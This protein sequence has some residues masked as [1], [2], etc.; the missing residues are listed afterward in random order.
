MD[1]KIGMTVAVMFLLI[2]VTMTIK[3]QI[4]SI[5]TSAEF[6]KDAVA[7]TTRSAATTLHIMG[8]SDDYEF[9]EF[10][11]DEFDDLMYNCGRSTNLAALEGDVKVARERN[12]GSCT[13]SREPYDYW[14]NNGILS[15]IVVV[16]ENGERSEWMVVG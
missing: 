3:A 13:D 4:S 1:K 5:E 14:E 11:R 15:G 12:L 6:S 7:H 9:G 8:S 16:E 10:G 2:I